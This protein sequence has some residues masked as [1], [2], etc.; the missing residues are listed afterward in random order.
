MPIRF[1][2]QD[3]IEE[4]G[5]AAFLRIEPDT[6][7]SGFIGAI[8]QINARGEPVEFTFSRVVTPESFMWRAGDLE[9][10][11]LKKLSMSLLTA[12]STIP[13]V[14]FCRASEVPVE[15]FR[16]AIQVTVP[17]CRILDDSTLA[18]TAAEDTPAMEW[19]GSSPPDA[20]IAA[21]LIRELERRHLLLEPFERARHGLNEVFGERERERGVT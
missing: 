11:A 19:Q 12:C 18:S 17:L 14:L 7:E 9:R 21:H 5:Y 2:D 13:N 15:L 3:D 6:V 1:V 8:L 20:S 4:L 16:D 10:S